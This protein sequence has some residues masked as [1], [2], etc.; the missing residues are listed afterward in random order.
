M[1]ERMEKVVETAKGNKST[2]NVLKYNHSQQGYASLPWR[3]IES[4]EVRTEKR[5][6]FRSWSYSYT[7]WKLDLVSYANLHILYFPEWHWNT[8]TI[9]IF[10]FIDNWLPATNADAK[11]EAAEAGYYVL[12][13][14]VMQ[15]H[16]SPYHRLPFP[17]F[18]CPLHLNM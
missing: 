5:K 13:H 12:Y 18:G 3:E 4:S 17:R 1:N 11:A 8:I 6:V 9:T 15:R 2:K 14:K 10:I 16:P 7:R